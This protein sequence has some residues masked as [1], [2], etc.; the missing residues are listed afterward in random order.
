M[1]KALGILM[2]LTFAGSMWLLVGVDWRIALGVYLFGWSLDI[3][4]G[5]KE[6]QK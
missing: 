1:K 5:I 2:I 3:G 6:M 4:N